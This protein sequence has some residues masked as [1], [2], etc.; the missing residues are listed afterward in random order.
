MLSLGID[1]A[2]ACYRE[3]LRLSEHSGD[4]L[5]LSSGYHKLAHLESSV[6]RY[7]V[8]LEHERRALELEQEVALL[9][10]A[11]QTQARIME[12]ELLVAS[13]PSSDR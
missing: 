4:D 13:R 2:R 1:K 12:L 5:A 7:D 3:A 8:A 10:V 11:E 6:H 9:T